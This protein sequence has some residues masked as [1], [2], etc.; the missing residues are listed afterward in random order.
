MFCC[1]V[2]DCDEGR[3]CSAVLEIEDGLVL[4]HLVLGRL[5]FE[6]VINTVNDVLA[7]LID[8]RKTVLF[9][10]L[11]LQPREVGVN[12]FFCPEVGEC[13]FDF[14]H[15]SLQILDAGHEILVLLAGELHDEANNR[16]DS[17]EAASHE[18]LQHARLKAA[19]RHGL[20][21]LEGVLVYTAELLRQFL[22]LWSGCLIFNG[23]KHL[24]FLSVDPGFNLLQ[25]AIEKGHLR[26][27]LVARAQL[28]ATTSPVTGTGLSSGS[29][30]PARGG[31]ELPTGLLQGRRLHRVHEVV[32]ND[33]SVLE[34]YQR[35]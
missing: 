35:L 16:F 27:V 3:F 33:L 4:D 20:S 10:G 25:I 26:D 2:Q 14:S 31:A 32:L 7:D 21:H 28:Q 6:E 15:V 5:A 29:D 18:R 23:L 1:Q 12:R 24:Y 22:L 34:L 19:L 17:C 8:R 9:P 30:E 13:A 11:G